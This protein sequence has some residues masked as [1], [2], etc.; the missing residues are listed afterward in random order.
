MLYLDCIHVKVRD[1]GTVRNKAINIAITVSP[2]IEKWSDAY[3]SIAKSW[4]NNW[5]HVIPFFAFPPE[6]RKII[7][8]T[9]AIESVN[10][11]LCKVTKIVA[12]FLMMTR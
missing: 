4:R 2:T 9:N 11:S 8:T 1:T 5:E 3:P 10:M 7:Y 6:I 12:H